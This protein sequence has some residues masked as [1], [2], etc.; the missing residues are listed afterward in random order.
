M[1]WYAAAALDR[2]SLSEQRGPLGRAADWLGAGVELLPALPGLLG[3]LGRTWQEF[4]AR[5][6]DRFVRDAFRSVFDVPEMPL[7]AGVTALAWMHARDAGYPLGGSLAFA[8][9]IE[10]RYRDLGGEVTYQARVA[11]ILVEHD[12]AI[13]AR[14]A[15]GAELRADDV[16][17]AADGHSTIFAL[18]EGGYVDAQLRR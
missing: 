17:S 15:D 14:L 18:L 6:T 11:G 1:T 2:P 12:R 8:Q 9:A 16:V 5:F 7:L 3:W 13:G 10:Q 4:A